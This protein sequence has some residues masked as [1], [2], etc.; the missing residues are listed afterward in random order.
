MLQL[1]QADFV[2]FTT[3][4]GGGTIE[5]WRRQWW[6]LLP[7]IFRSKSAAACDL[8]LLLLLML[9]RKHGF[10]IIYSNWRDVKMRQVEN[11]IL[12]PS[13]SPLRSE[14]SKASIQHVGR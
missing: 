8:M 14:G 7:L 9:L 6:V 4:G 12:S 11:K 1:Q 3:F 2:T 5:K 10:C 13:P